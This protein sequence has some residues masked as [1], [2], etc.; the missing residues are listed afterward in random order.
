MNKDSKIWELSDSDFLNFLYTERNREYSKHS[1]WG[2]NFWVIVAA[3]VGLFGY[4][5]H[6][7][8]SDYLHFDWRLVVYYSTVIGALVICGLLLL[9][10]FVRNNR[11]IS[12]YR[13]TT[14]LYNA[15][16]VLMFGKF[17]IAI[18]S[19]IFLRYWDELGI[20]YCLWIVFI[21]LEDCAIFYVLKNRDKVIKVTR[22]GCVFANNKIEWLYRIIEGLICFTIF[23]V[24]LCTW[25]KELVFGVR[26]FEISCILAMIVGLIWFSLCRIYDKRY[27]SMDWWIDQYIYGNLTKKEAYLYLL[28]YS[29]D[30]DIVD[31]LRNEYEKIKPLQSEISKWRETH[32]EYIRLI[33]EGKLELD[34]CKKYITFIDNETSI[35]NNLLNK[36]TIVN[37]KIKEI[38]KL[39]T[40]PASMELFK[41]LMNEI[42][43]LEDDVFEC[44]EESNKICKELKLFV[45]SYMCTKY[46]G[47]CGVEDCV[48]RNEKP[49]IGYRIKH[50]VK[51]LFLKVSFKRKENS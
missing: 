46:G 31:I 42:H 26:E 17:T 38:L 48:H 50:G 20:I 10:P 29:Q 4:A 16:T 35:S 12:K 8:S 9:L 49:S 40:L 5:Y 23:I 51:V 34:D 6:T 1:E 25:G 33:D 22:R 32:K 37:D 28:E 14:I 43:S 30:Y 7:I 24:A 45:I 36:F 44:I 11:W 19:S 39:E 13:V 18:T 47:M 27:R 21:L 41:K 15:P 2:V 3:I